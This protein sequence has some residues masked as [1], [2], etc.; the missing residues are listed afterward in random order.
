MARRSARPINRAILAHASGRRLFALALLLVPSSAIAGMLTLAA[1]AA[2]ADGFGGDGFV[3]ALGVGGGNPT[4]YNFNPTVNL[5]HWRAAKAAV[6]AGT[7]RA[8]LDYAGD[9]TT[10]GWGSGT[11]GTAYT[12]AHDLSGA[13]QSAHYMQVGGLPTTFD[14]QM[15]GIGG[16]MNSLAFLAAYNQRFSITGS[17]WALLPNDPTINTLGGTYVD[18]TTT[19]ADLLKATPAV[20]VDTFKIFAYQ[21]TPLGSYSWNIDGGADT[22]INQSAL[23]ASVKITTVS[24]TKGA[25]VL[26]LKRVS[27]AAYQIGWI[28]YDSTT[29][30]ID[31]VKMGWGGSTSSNWNPTTTGWEPVSAIPVLGAAL[32]VINLGINDWETGIPPATTAANIQA[33]ITAQKNAGGD[34]II[35][36]PTP[37]GGTAS[38]ATQ[39][40]YLPPLIAL[41]NSNNI[42][43]INWT[44]RYT[45]WA[46]QNARG[47]TYDSLHPNALLYNDEGQFLAQLLLGA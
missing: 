7:G 15:G 47:W 14:S 41:A 31:V 43:L 30:A 17:G 5:T 16:G 42:P 37:T 46:V 23:P 39:A 36:M 38:P 29:P 25:H 24:T 9:S 21:N 34:V 35:C 6:L 45:S 20:Q 27:G 40:T 11:G 19:T 13:M 2:W 33:L 10:L 3:Q 18:N 12:G 26:N 28:A 22:T 32:L 1:G 44:A 8:T 4:V